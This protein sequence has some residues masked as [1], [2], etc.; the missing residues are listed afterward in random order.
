MQSKKFEDEVKVAFIKGC[1]HHAKES[2]LEEK[3]A[4]REQRE[5]R[6]HVDDHLDKLEQ[7]FRE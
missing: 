3:E 6:K 4:K 7:H 1:V 5:F 2:T